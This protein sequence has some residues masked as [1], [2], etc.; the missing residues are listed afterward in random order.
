MRSYIDRFTQILIEVDGA[1]EGLQC[2]I[3][4][5]DLLSAHSFRKKLGKRKVKYVQKILIMAEPFM[6]IEENL[7]HITI[8]PHLASII[9]I[10][11]LEKNLTDVE[12]I[13]TEICK[14]N[15]TDTSY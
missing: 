10:T 2:W 12:M 14:R 9:P 13:L 3:F 5:N 7:P 1:Q 4:E 11:H 6:I 8:T 15:M